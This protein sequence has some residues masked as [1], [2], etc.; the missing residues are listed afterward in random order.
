MHVIKDIN[1]NIFLE[2]E[3]KE[4]LI[5]KVEKVIE[6]LTTF[7]FVIYSW[8]FFNY[9]DK[10]KSGNSFILCEVNEDRAY[11]IVKC[12]LNEKNNRIESIV[13]PYLFSSSYNPLSM[14]QKLQD[15]LNKYKTDSN[16]L[17]WNI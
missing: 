12:N 10:V 4:Q 1:N 2:A 9:I 16:V 13:K 17:V 8:E 5:F 15:T 7:P 11:G 6:R 3:N 14:V